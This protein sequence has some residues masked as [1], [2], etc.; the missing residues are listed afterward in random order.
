MSK[1]LLP[2]VALLCLSAQAAWLESIRWFRH[3]DFV[4]VVFDLSEAA[5]Y[6]VA[7]RLSEG[8]VDVILQGDLSRRMAEEISIEEGG[9]LSAR[10]LR[11]TSTSL[12]WRIQVSKVARVKHMSLEEKPYKVALDFYPVRG[13]S[14]AKTEAPAGKPSGAPAQA[15]GK[16]LSRPAAG[17]PPA[18]GTRALTSPATAGKTG[19]KPAAPAGHASPAAAQQAK[20]PEPTVRGG[21]GDGRLEGLKPDER[22]RVLVGELLLQLGDSAGAMAYLEQVSA[23]QPAH[24]WTRFLLAQAYLSKGDQFRAQKLLEPMEGKAEWTALLEPLKRRMHPPDEKGQVPGGEISEADLSYFIGVLRHGAGLSAKDLYTRP[25]EPTP[26][27][28]HAFSRMLSI[29]LGGLTGLVVFFL[30]DLRRRR[31]QQEENRRRILNDEGPRRN[32]PLFAPA[33]DD[34][35]Y[36]EVARRVREE[37]DQVLHKEPHESEAESGHGYSAQ[38]ETSV[39]GKMSLEEQVYQLADQKRSIVE[40]AEEL[41]LGVDEVRLHLELREQA[42]RISNA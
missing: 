38:E 26:S 36:S 23:Q 4:R 14:K 22:R 9:V 29:I 15:A 18:G 39:V 16:A 41:N 13:S 1:L 25:A 6:R 3:D 7:E 12:T 27:G 40:I 20:K 24:A 17:H 34:R 5:D 21:A 11:K 33:Q 19:S 30:L 37:L 31:S 8:Y 42:G 2:L 35:D 10:Q 28:S 32:A